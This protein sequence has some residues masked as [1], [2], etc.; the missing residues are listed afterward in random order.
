MVNDYVE[1]A[2]TVSVASRYRVQPSFAE[3]VAPRQPAQ[4]QPASAKPPMPHDR[5]IGVLAAGWKVF[6]L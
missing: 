5:H 1:K 3:R 2:V 4:G 6:A